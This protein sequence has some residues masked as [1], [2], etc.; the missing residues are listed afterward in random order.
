ME[1]SFSEE[2]LRV[3]SELAAE[4]QGLDFA[5]GD[6]YDFTRCVRPDGSAYGTSGRCRKG[7]ETGAKGTEGEAKG[8]GSGSPGVRT[9]P[10]GAIES[11]IRALRQKAKGRGLEAVK[12]NTEIKKLEAE[13]AKP[14]QGGNRDKMTATP[15]MAAKVRA[16]KEKLKAEKAA[17][18]G[19][20]SDRTQ[21]ERR[22]EQNR[23]QR[24]RDRKVKANE[25]RQREML[26]RSGDS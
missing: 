20:R 12:A 1:G 14:L 13:L 2:A 23:Q 17:N 15:G 8:G 10:R 16:A 11:D 24:E 18:D 25:E 26:R 21:E 3:Y 4:K 6:S 19:K 22:L 7:T 5:E 9:R